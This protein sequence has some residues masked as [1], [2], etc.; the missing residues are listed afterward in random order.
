[1]PENLYEIIP[2]APENVKIAAMR[3]TS[4]RPLNLQ[5]QPVY[6]APH[7]GPTHRQPAHQRELVSSQPAISQC[8]HRRTQRRPVYGAGNPHPCPGRK[9][10]LDRA[11]YSQLDRHFRF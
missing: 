11:G 6:P 3:V 2:G 4:Q 1:M 7:V 9:F 5:R 10:D 8:R